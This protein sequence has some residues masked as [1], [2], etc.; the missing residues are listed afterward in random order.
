[1]TRYENE[2]I[3]PG[4]R[5]RLRDDSILWCEV[6]DQLLVL[7]PSGEDYLSLNR[8]AVPLWDRLR[9]GATTFELAKLLASRYH[10]PSD[11]AQHDA[12]RFV[13]LLATRGLLDV[14]RLEID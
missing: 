11:R 2:P 10:L 8:S 14:S 5:V 3:A 9:R 12:A 7:L 13:T 1:M 4:D 6:G